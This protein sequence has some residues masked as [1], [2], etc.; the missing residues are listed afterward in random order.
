M[1]KK[2]E[3][4][5][6]SKPLPKKAKNIERNRFNKKILNFIYNSKRRANSEIT[7][8]TKEF[9]IDLFNKNKH[10]AICRTE[11]CLDGNKKNGVQ[12]DH[13]I[14]LKVGGKNIKDNIRVICH[15]CNKK[16]PQ[17]G[18]DESFENKSLLDN[19][20]NVDN[21]KPKKSKK[22]PKIINEDDVL[23]SYQNEFQLTQTQQ[24]ILNVKLEYPELTQR[25]IAKKLKLNES[26]ISELCN[27]PNFIKAWN[28]TQKKAIDILIKNKTKAVLRIVKHITSKDDR[29][30]LKAAEL[31]AGDLLDPKRV[32]I[33]VVDKEQAKKEIQEMFE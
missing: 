13:I 6:K 3:I 16:R 11:L 28:D 33:Q 9:L 22:I 1:N 12:F 27:K 8:I 23:K 31:I 29:V 32:T 18:S 15:S 21:I 20:L 4:K 30:S 19:D 25:Q 10:C 2:T 24:I 14:P 7:D 5:N 26:H 17:D